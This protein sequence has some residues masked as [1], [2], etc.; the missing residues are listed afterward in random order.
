MS[1]AWLTYESIKAELM[2]LVPDECQGCSTTETL[3]SWPVLSVLNGEV[4]VDQVKEGFGEVMDEI[5]E[6]CRYGLK[7][8]GNWAPPHAALV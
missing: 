5:R 4:T 3:L 6:N 8:G 2:P 7:R 1:E